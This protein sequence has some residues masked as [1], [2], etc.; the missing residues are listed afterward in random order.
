M[1]PYC[2]AIIQ[3]RLFSFRDRSML[4]E[5]GIQLVES[6]GDGGHIHNTGD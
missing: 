6:S 5:L 4:G 1:K 2:I 3:K